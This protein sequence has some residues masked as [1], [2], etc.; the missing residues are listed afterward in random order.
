LN[1]SASDIFIAIQ[2]TDSFFPRN[3]SLEKSQVEFKLGLIDRRTEHLMLSV[4]YQKWLNFNKT[5]QKATRMMF[6]FT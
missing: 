6:F 5:D 4:I 1:I 2:A 3:V